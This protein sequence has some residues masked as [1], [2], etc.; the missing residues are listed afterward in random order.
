MF[1]VRRCRRRERINGYS[2]SRSAAAS[3]HGPLSSVAAINDASVIRRPSVAG[4]R[5]VH[6][7]PARWPMRV[8]CLTVA[9]CRLDLC[10]RAT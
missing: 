6:I 10:S 8:H 4:N 1:L 9:G 5:P 7:S 2:D 3:S